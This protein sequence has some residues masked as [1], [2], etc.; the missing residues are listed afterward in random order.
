MKPTALWFYGFILGLAPL[1]FA[2]ASGNSAPPPLGGL[3]GGVAHKSAPRIFCV[4][5]PLL[6]TGKRYI[7]YILKVAARAREV[8]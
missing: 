2:L 3:R 5:K 8:P 6:L 4:S 1:A 7:I